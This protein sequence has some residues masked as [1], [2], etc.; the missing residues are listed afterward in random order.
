MAGTLKVKPITVGFACKDPISVTIKDDDDNAVVTTAMTGQPTL[1]PNEMG[2]PTSVQNHISITNDLD[3]RNPMNVGVDTVTWTLR[4]ECG[5]VMT[6]CKQLVTVQY[7]PCDTVQYMGYDY[8]AVRIGHQCWLA[9]NLRYEYGNYTSY[10][11]VTDNLD[12]FG[13][14]YSWYTAV[15]VPEGTTTVDPTFQTADNGSLY[16]QGICPKGWAVGSM[17]DFHTLELTA[18]SM[19]SLKD[20]GTAYWLSG[21]EGDDPGTGF[22]A[23]G[24]GWYNSTRSRYEDI[25]TGFHFW[26]ADAPVSPR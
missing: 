16:V 21:Y 4:D 1:D 18:G 23:R 25:L 7:K 10:N 17:E 15:G 2:L 9:E 20:P 3:Q 8:P 14:L 22:N 26:R 6:T 12:K 24:G 5:N 13:Y 19:A 11:N